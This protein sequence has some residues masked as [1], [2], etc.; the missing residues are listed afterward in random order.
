M[1]LLDYIRGLRKG[2]EAHRLEKESMQDPFLADAMDGYNQVEGNHEQRIEKLR[3]QV[4]AHSA[5]KKNTY[6][7]TW[8]IAACLVIGFGISSYFLFLKKSMTD[9]VFIAE[10]SVPA[11]LP[12]ATTP[13]T[14]TNPAT[15]A[16]PVTPRADKKE[17]SASAVIEPMM[18]EALE[19]TAELQEV[20]ATMDTSESAS[21]KKM[22]MAKVVTIPNSNIIQGKVTDE[23]GEP[24]I[25]ASVAYKGTN[26]G[27]ITNMNGEFSLVKKEG[28]KQLTAQFIGYDPV[29]I[30]VDTSQT[31]LIAM[32][33]NKQTLNEVAVVGY[34]TNKNKKSTTVVTAKE[35]A[36]KDMTPQ[37]V[38]GKRKYQKYLK[39]NL[40]RP[41]DEK[42]AQ[43]KGK[44]VLTFLVNKEGR[45]FYIKVKESL[46]E[47]SDKEAI[48]LIQE[49]PDWIYG[50]KS[51]E[52][53]VKFE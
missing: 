31:M 3:M 2:K 34:G 10:E 5:K 20:A 16:A 12:E 8:S 46:C 47:S 25:G 37:P 9:E 15:P 36:D 21:D 48:R 18:E 6:A 49:G 27:T 17:M 33:E 1:K 19:Q 35:Q 53:T 45:P 32:N 7:I 26:I 24:I 11:K 22:R 43:V 51:V 28:K 50:N 39:E 4:S 44:V 23:K 41:T 29:E 40:V 14:P 52:I 38:I 42:C 13:A 30:P